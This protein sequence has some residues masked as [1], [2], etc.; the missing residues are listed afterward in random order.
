MITALALIIG[1]ALTVWLWRAGHDAIIDRGPAPGERYPFWDDHSLGHLLGAGGVT[2][3]VGLT[4][5]A[6]AGALVSLFLWFLVEVAQ[7]NPYDR[8]G[9]HFGWEDIAV[10]V[11]GILLGVGFLLLIGLLT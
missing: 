5:G 9:G 1:V 6:L 3:A 10:D 2:V 7:A 4:D 11:I 8:R